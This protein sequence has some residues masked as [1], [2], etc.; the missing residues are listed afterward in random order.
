MGPQVSPAYAGGVESTPR[1][2]LVVGAG[3]VGL[4]SAWRLARH[5][6]RVTVLDPAPGAGATYAAAGMIAAS[7]EI[8]PGEE[9]NYRLHRQALGSWRTLSEELAAVTHRVV[10]VHET[11][12]LV[13]GWDA[14]DRAMVR[15]FSGVAAGFGAAGIEVRREDAPGAFISLSDRLSEGLLMRGDGWLDPDEAVDAL[16]A[17]LAALDV[18]MVRS[19]VLEVGGDERSVTARTDAAQFHGDAGILATGW[20]P[21]PSGAHASGEFQVRPVHGVTVRVQGLDRADAPTVRA[22][23]RGRPFYLVSR[24]GGYCVL[25]ASSEERAERA[26][27]V[28]E[29]ARILRDALDVAP[30]LET[31]E[32]LES[33]VGLRP[34]SLD[35]RPF[36]ERLEP[37][38]WAWSTGYYRHGVTMAPWAAERA[39][40][41]VEE[42]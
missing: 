11:G 17:G 32:V 8:A 9:D 33:R 1:S 14:G 20:S 42:S 38:G 41:F 3:I 25:G 5:G 26:V 40:A 7:A 39:L 37:K 13:V 34:A 19:E 24:A 27:Q 30:D 36:F 6:H 12:T 28:G 4:T 29:L 31:A 23:V 21:L 2:V 35:G 18:T 22:Y 15:Q 10:N 16:T